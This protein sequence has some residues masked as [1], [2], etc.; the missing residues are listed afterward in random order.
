VPASDVP[1]EQASPTQPFPRQGV[2]TEQ[3]FAARTPECEQAVQ[4]LRYEG[5]FTPPSLRGSLL[6]PGNVGGANWGGGAYDARRGLVFV[7]N[8]RLAT[9]VQLIPREQVDQRRASTGE[10]IGEEFAV[11]RGTPYAMVRRT[12]LDRSGQPCNQPPWGVLAALEVSTGKVRWEAPLSVYLGGPLALPEGVVFFAGT[13]L[14]Q[15]LRAFHADTGKLLWETTLP[16]SAQSTPAHYVHQG[17][18]YIVIAAGGHGKVRS[19]QGDHVVAFRL[20]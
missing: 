12:F 10:R 8:N 9:V 20:P 13:I 16:A 7:G 17:R 15:Q 4:G 18:H 3:R 2:F 19:K 14:D 6:F 11:Q 5:L 1:G